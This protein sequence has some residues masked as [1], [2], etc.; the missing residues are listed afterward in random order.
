MLVN[1]DPTSNFDKLKTYPDFSVL[2]QFIWRRGSKDSRGQ[3]L[4]R[5]TFKGGAS[6][7]G[8]FQFYIAPLDP[9]LKVG[10]FG[11][12]SGQVFVL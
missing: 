1:I 11:E 5:P 2:L 4:K 6:R 12:Q 9:S 10:I 8:C 3:G 7:Y